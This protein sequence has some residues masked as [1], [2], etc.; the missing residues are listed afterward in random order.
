MQRQREMARAAWAGSGESATETVW[1]AV[2]DAVGA[3]EFLGYEAEKTEGVVAALVRDGKRVDTIANGDTGLLVANQTP[4]YAE[5]GGQVGDTGTIVGA[6]FKARVTNVE[7][8]LGDLWVHHVTVE[9]GHLVVG[10]PAEFTVDHARRATIRAHH[11]ATHLLHEAL[12]QVLGD[13]VAQKGS[14]VAPDR[15]RFD[16]SHPK[17]I[18]EEELGPRIEQPRQRAPFSAGNGSR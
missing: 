12:R 2:R 14:L 15:L 7:K 8:K 1:Y 13:H 18:S 9:D 4:F 11:S 17:P 16:I 3:T 5:S 6:G 10:H